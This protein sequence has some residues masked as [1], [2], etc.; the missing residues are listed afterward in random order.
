M[1]QGANLGFQMQPNAPPSADP[2]FYSSPFQEQNLTQIFGNLSLN[3]SQMD[4][5]N[6]STS[7]FTS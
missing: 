2:R 4:L 7:P 5:M 6:E 1:K 3:E